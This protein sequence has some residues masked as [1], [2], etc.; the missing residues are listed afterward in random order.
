MPLIEETYQMSNAHKFNISLEA[1]VVTAQTAVD[2][3]T[4]ARAAVK[5]AATTKAGLA[6]MEGLRG[7]KKYLNDLFR[8]DKSN[9]EVIVQ[10]LRNGL[11]QVIGELAGEASD[12]EQTVRFGNISVKVRE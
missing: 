10:I 5:V 1:T 2:Q 8:S 4:V 7:D 6:K 3:L 12:S 11:R 9:E